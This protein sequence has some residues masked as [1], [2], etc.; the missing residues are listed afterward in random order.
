MNQI[1]FTMGNKLK[2]PKSKIDYN[3]FDDDPDISSPSDS[4]SESVY[5]ASDLSWY[6]YLEL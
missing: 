2:K 5:S 6:D 4:L 3:C 1:S